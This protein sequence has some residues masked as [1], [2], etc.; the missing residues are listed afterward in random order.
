MLQQDAD[1]L[2]LDQLAECL[3]GQALAERGTIFDSTL[4]AAHGAIDCRIGYYLVRAQHL[5]E[6]RLRQEPVQTDFLNLLF[7]GKRRRSYRLLTNVIIWLYTSGVF[8]AMK[9]QP[10][11]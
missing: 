10:N 3:I 1:T 5:E 9:A 4:A 8:I 2:H 11:G 7:H 6:C